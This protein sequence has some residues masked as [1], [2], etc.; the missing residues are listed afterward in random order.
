MTKNAEYDISK[1]LFDFEAYASKKHTVYPEL[2]GQ[3]FEI[4]TELK[5]SISKFNKEE[6]THLDKDALERR[7]YEGLTP[8]ASKFN[9]AFDYFYRNE[10]YLSKNTA[11]AYE[12]AMRTQ[13][14]FLEKIGVNFQENLNDDDWQDPA[15]LLIKTDQEH[16]HSIKEK[17]SALKEIMYKELSYTHFEEP[18]KKEEALS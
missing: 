11:I 3:A 2:Y 9:T 12:D 13:F 15:F 1:K 14:S 16:Y 6:K 8:I 7:F 17:M 10:L 5:V 4:W 18:E